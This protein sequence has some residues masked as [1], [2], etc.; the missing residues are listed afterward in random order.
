MSTERPS[1]RLRTCPPPTPD[2]TRNC[3]LNTVPDDILRLILR[4][5]SGRPL[6][7][8][9]HPYI[10]VDAVKT[11]VDIGGALGRAASIEF[12]IIG[13]TDGIPLDTAL[14]A[15]VLRSLVYRLPLQ[16]LEIQ[17]PGRL[18]W[19][20]T[21]KGIIGEFHGDDLLPRIL[22][23]C[24]AELRELVLDTGRIV[25]SE[26]DI[27][28]I[29]THCTKLSSVAVRGT[30]IEG[31]LAPIWRSLGSTLIRVYIGRYYSVFGIR[32]RKA[33][34]ESDLVQHCLNLYRVDVEEIDDAVIDVLVT[35]GSRIRVLSIKDASYMNIAH[36]CELYEACTN[37]EGFHLVLE[38]CSA[39]NI[40]VPSVM[41]TKLVSLKMESLNDLTLAGDR[42]FS[43]LSA[44]SI[45]KEVQLHV[46]EYIP[47]ELL[48]KLFKSLKSVAT[49]EL[50]V[51]LSDG[52]S[53]KD[54]ID[55]IASNVTNLENLV[56][57][58][59][60]QVKADNVKA[61]VDLPHLKSVSLQHEFYLESGAEKCAL[62]VVK[63]LKNCA[64]LVQL[65]MGS[66]NIE[67]RSAFIAEAAVMYNRKDFDMFIGG[68]QYRTW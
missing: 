23:G 8:S 44:C 62:E 21:P 49:I 55:A 64:Q 15:S 42:I 46:W 43:V 3:Y 1:K 51:G 16:K 20:C 6:C 58:T 50:V 33:F 40:D 57:R 41:R 12:N 11:A 53:N 32:D 61:L 66:I 65:E 10:S 60:I 68:V 28:A 36:C 18:I 54:F 47:E 31:T 56:F 35:L 17:L 63:R 9:W 2:D 25:L 34:S 7:E 24:G 59:E 38:G 19:V 29:S 30:R 14:D 52:N 37:L 22:P 13:G 45:L 48:R 27:L 67:N 26:K 5:L 39:E 4:Y